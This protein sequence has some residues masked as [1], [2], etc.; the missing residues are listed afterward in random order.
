MGQNE[1][2]LIYRVRLDFK[3]LLI[4]GAICFLSPS[5]SFAQND[6]LLTA[7]IH[8]Y[9][10]STGNTKVRIANKI[11][12]LKPNYSTVSAL[13]KEADFSNSVKTG[14]VDCEVVT[15][16]G[17]THLNVV[18]VPYDYTPSKKYR[19][20]IMLHG[21]VNNWNPDQVSGYINKSDT[22][23]AN[24][25]EVILFP[26]AWYKS[27]WTDIS[28]FENITTLIAFVKQTYN[29]DDNALHLEGISDGGVGV[30][31][32]A[33]KY[34]TA[35]ASFVP[36]IG[37]MAGL[38]GV[39]TS[40]YYLPNYTGLPFFIVNTVKDSIFTFNVAAGYVAELQKLSEPISFFSVDTSGHSLGWYPVLRDT[41]GRFIK[42]VRRNPFPEA[43]TFV[44]DT[45]HSYNRKFWVEILALGKVKYECA[46]DD[47]NLVYI[48]G[49]VFLAFH[50]NRK[51]GQIEVRKV[52]NRVDV[53]T[54]GVRRFK[55]LIS[56]SSFDLTQP[57]EVYTNG[58]LSFS[59]IVIPNVKTLLEYNMVDCDREML[60]GAAI[61]IKVGKKIKK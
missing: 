39:S 31:H 46:L 44:V 40:P 43:I 9:K 52:A 53:K 58:I 48:D 14:F 54:S 12:A 21:A 49:K 50:H 42:Q 35:F 32:V 59:S 37:S 25:H 26:A 41:L 34:P 30:Y 51:F 19:V 6:S 45:V 11:V 33:N 17:L 24:V 16:D 7:L 27:R 28:Q 10:V 4:W 2:H 47:P 18:F 20:R 29:V 56:P 5:R 15:S 61:E 1:P 13:L 60:F 36:L 22:S 23:W 8:Q 57:I 3:F 38:L 55:L